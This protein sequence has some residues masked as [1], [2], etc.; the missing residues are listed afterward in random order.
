M[1]LQE[2]LG[3]EKNPDVMMVGVVSRL[4]WQKRILSIDGTIRCIMCCSYSIGYFG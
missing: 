1:A 2:E 3:L 4:T